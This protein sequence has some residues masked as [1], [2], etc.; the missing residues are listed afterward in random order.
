M[1]AEQGDGGEERISL[2]TE[3]KVLVDSDFHC[4]RY[5]KRFLT[6]CNSQH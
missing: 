4:L 5:I 3:R 2:E 6:M 1:R